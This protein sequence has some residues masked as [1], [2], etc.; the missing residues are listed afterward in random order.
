MI[1]LGH[2]YPYQAAMILGG[3]LLAVAALLRL[4]LR[5]TE[6]AAAESVER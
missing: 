4:L 6:T 3:V 1:W 2:L 5:L